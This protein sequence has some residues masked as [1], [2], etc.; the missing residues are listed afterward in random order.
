[1]RKQKIF[2]RR[3]HILGFSGVESASRQ[4]SSILVTERVPILII[5]SHIFHDVIERRASESCS[6][7]DI[8]GDKSAITMVPTLQLGQ[9]HI[10]REAAQFNA[11]MIKGYL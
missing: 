5:L 7:R 4:D 2:F 11:E 8:F 10:C 3:G 6:R 9:D 1:M